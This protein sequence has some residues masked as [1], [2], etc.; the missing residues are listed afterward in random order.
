MSGT[1][2]LC[3]HP[4]RQNVNTFVPVHDKI[5][6]SPPSFKKVSGAQRSYPSN[7]LYAVQLYG[8]SFQDQS[9]LGLA[10]EKQLKPLPIN[11]FTKTIAKLPAKS[12]VL[13]YLTSPSTQ[14]VLNDR[15]IVQLSVTNV[16]NI[17]AKHQLL[18]TSEIHQCY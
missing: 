16:K 3:I 13:L 4:L 8:L 5:L 9:R 11:H 12:R 10:K 7:Q 2:E 14:L 1:R 6:T 18:S 17:Q 15:L